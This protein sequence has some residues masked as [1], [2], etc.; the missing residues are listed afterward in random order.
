MKKLIPFLATLICLI[1]TS[2]AQFSPAPDHLQDQYFSEEIQQFEVLDQNGNSVSLKSIL[3][4]HEGK[5]VVLDFW[6]SWCKDCRK[7]MPI[8]QALQTE[9]ENVNY[10]FFSMD[11]STERWLNAIVKMNIQGDHYFIKEGW[12][13]N[14]LTDYLGLDWI[15]RYLVLDEKGKILLAKAIEAD[16]KE[17]REIVLKK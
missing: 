10:V 14:K 16:N 12:G 17:L 4:N 6:A 8:L 2:C 1:S 5:K 15:P 11:K 13:S 9:T 7:G 3:Q